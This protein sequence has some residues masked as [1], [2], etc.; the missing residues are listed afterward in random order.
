MKPEEYIDE[1]I[2]IATQAGQAIRDIYLKGSFEREIKSDN[3]PVTSADLAANRIICD[4]L[5]ALTPTIPILSEEAADIPLSDRALWKRY[6]LVDPLDGTGEF[7]AGS[8]DFAVIIAL[9]EHNRP[10]MGV[11]YVP[12]TQVCYYAI[13]GLGAYKRTDKQELRITSR[14]ISQSESVCLRL[15]VSRRQEPQSV[16]TL[17]NQ[18]QHCELV[19][20]GGAALKSCLVAEGRADCYVRV[21]PTGEWDTGAAQIIIEEAGGQLMDIELQPLSYNERESLENPNFI[22]VGSPNLAWDEILIGK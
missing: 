15:A 2:A 13:A 20:M 3:T 4:R 16:L 1:V 19:V 11:V 21:G 9:V 10:V 5:S 8:G 22:V 17:F 18:P 6:W 12:M 14:Q 7:I